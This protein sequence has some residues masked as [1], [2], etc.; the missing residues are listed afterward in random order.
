MLFTEV[1]AKN[2]DNIH[3]LFEKISEAIMTSLENAGK[4]VEKN[5]KN[6]FLVENKENDQDEK[7]KKKC[8]C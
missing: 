2:G 4:L 5:N 6:K 7:E 3:I 8:F 1:S